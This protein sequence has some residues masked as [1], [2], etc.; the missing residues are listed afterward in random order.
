[1]SLYMDIRNHE[2]KQYICKGSRVHL[3]GIGGVSMRPLGIVLQ[4]MGLI[5]TGSDMNSSVSTD[6]LIAHGVVGLYDNCRVK[7][8]NNLYSDGT[9]TYMMVRTKRAIAFAQQLSEIDA[10]RPEKRFADAVKG[11][12]L[13]DGK[14]VRPAEI[15][16]INVKYA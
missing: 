8:S 1:M 2:I 15:V 5:V 4:E 12:A 3:V 13:F 6:E 11:F 10:Y 14:V 16:N 7:L 9:D